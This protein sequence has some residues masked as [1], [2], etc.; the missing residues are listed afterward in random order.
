M[1]VVVLLDKWKQWFSLMNVFDLVGLMLFAMTFETIGMIMR[2]TMFSPSSSSCDRFSTQWRQWLLLVCLDNYRTFQ[3]IS[4]FL[5]TFSSLQSFHS[6]NETFPTD[7]RSSFNQRKR[8]VLIISPNTYVLSRWPRSKVNEVS[9]NKTTDHRS[10][11]SFV[12][13]HR[14]ESD[15]H[16]HL[17]FSFERFKM[18]FFS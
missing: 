1:E 15:E 2:R 4:V 12:L 18:R 16:L 7:S 13:I 14:I 8:L 3:F 6:F 9:F 17:S 11:L 10:F 5:F